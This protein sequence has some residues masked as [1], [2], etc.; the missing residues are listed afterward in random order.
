MLEL[1]V[2]NISGMAYI[3]RD[4]VRNPIHTFTVIMQ[5]PVPSV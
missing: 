3:K 5:M 2:I 4:G 1:D